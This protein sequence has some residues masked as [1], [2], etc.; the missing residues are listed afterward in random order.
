MRLHR[1]IAAALGYDLIR[2]AKN[3]TT[4]TAHLAALFAH[5]RI[6][7]VID[8]GANTGQYATSLRQSGY[9]GDIVSF[10]PLPSCFDELRRVSRGDAAWR[11]IN[12][13]LANDSG[14]KRIH[15][16][17]SSVYSSFL[18]F[19]DYG[20][21]RYEAAIGAE[22]EIEV[23]VARLDAVIREISDGARRMFL[24]MDTQG[25]DL[26]VFNGARDCLPYVRGLQSEMS[27][28]P[29]YQGMPNYRD[30]LRIYSEAGFEPSGFYPVTRDQNSLGIVEFDCVLVRAGGGTDG[31]RA[32][33]APA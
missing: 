17:E 21:R 13:A 4:L 22:T 28:I 23:R 26:E 10:E 1:R 15:E 12:I 29:I 19:N 6:D 27:V 11:I 30:A 24:K 8:V 16:T 25:Y 14:T 2:R 9:R 3:H 7:L 32:Q 20:R 33:R 31:S 18:A 5:E